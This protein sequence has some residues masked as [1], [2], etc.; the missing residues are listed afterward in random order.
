VC[1]E[2]KRQYSAA[3]RAL[4]PPRNHNKPWSTDDLMLVDVLTAE[5]SVK[6]IAK[7]L[8]RSEGSVK[9]IRYQDKITP[10]LLSIAEITRL[11][12]RNLTENGMRM[13]LNRLVAQGAL[14][15]KKVG[16]YRFFDPDAVE[17]VKDVL[18]APRVRYKWMDAEVKR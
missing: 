17:A 11:Y 16:K 7:R 10:D 1:R 5:L 6:D 13:R 2:A 18:S 15:A 8:G 9:R 3:Q 12:G 14:I 4:K